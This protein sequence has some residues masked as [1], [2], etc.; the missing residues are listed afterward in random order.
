MIDRIYDVS[1]ILKLGREYETGGA[2]D[3]S[4]H[5]YYLVCPRVGLPDE[6]GLKDGG[7]GV[8]EGNACVPPS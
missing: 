6:E 3:I 8:S 5:R 1:D 7:L 2:R 4:L